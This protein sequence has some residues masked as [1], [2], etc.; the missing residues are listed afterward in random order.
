MTHILVK[1]GLSASLAILASQSDAFAGGR[2]GGGSRGGYGGE[3]R[4]GMQSGSMSHSPS[5]SQPHSSTSEGNRNSSNPN[6]GA[7]AAGAGASNRNQQPNHSNAGAAAVGTGASNRN[8]SDKPSNA[9]AA[10]AGAGAANRNQQPSVSN[11]GAAAAGAGAANRNQQ[12]NRSNAGAAAAGAGYSNR[13]QQPN[14]SNAGA[15]AAG[16]GY[17]NRNQQPNVSNA[18]AAAAGAGYANRNQ[19]P[20]S[21]A[22]AAAAGA[23]YANRNQY[24]NYNTGMGYGTWNGNYGTGMGNYGGMAMAAPVSGGVSPYMNPYASNGPGVVA[25][26]GG[27]AQ[28]APDNVPAGNVPAANTAPIDYSQPLNTAAAPPDA[29]QGDPATSPVVQARQAFH[30]GDYL[31]ALK[32]TNQA[33][34]QSP[35]DVDLH[36]LLALDLF[37]QGNYEQAA[38]PLYAVLA[39]GP[40]WNWTTLIGN[41]SDA[42]AYTGQLRGLEAFVKANPR[43]AQAQFVLA[44]QYI[45][46]GQG[47]SAIRPLENVVT[48]QPNDK[49][50][51][52]LIAMLQP[53]AGAGEAPSTTPT[54]TN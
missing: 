1:L 32:L 13:N 38:A 42:S 39:V 40:G 41:Y 21:N 51:A 30:E 6:A 45:C 19:S 33:L 53:P 46:Q 11:A 31:N 24:G 37:A 52:Q 3:S 7:A 4:G 48:L 9:G 20:Y 14:V 28:P 50:S 10:A 5:F 12:P 35:N 8:Q 25:V 47:A 23:A 22:G 18:G 27:Q 34:G 26:G 54:S 15:T 17:A 2:G 36:Q 16:A 49:L 44:Y 29:P 43:S